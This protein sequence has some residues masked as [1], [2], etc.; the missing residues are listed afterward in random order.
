MIYK[1]PRAVNG[2]IHNLTST[3][4]EVIQYY[5]LTLE[6]HS[7]YTTKESSEIFT[8]VRRCVIE[9]ENYR[10]NNAL[11]IR[12]CCVHAGIQEIFD[13]SGLPPKPRARNTTRGNDCR[14]GQEELDRSEHPSAEYTRVYWGQPPLAHIPKFYKVQG[15][16]QTWPSSFKL[17]SSR[18]EMPAQGLSFLSALPGKCWGGT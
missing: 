3:F 8:L 12:C 6:T 14:A 15:L 7:L 4:P 10:A 5:L 11:M 18:T 1:L 16:V 2:Q 17:G 9:D 13:G